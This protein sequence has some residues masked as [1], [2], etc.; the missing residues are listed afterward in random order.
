MTP[1]S[2]CICAKGAFLTSLTSQ[3]CGKAYMLLS[4][5]LIPEEKEDM[6]RALPT[7][8]AIGLFQV[9]EAL[10]SLETQADP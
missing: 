5:T 1:G 3:D 6:K 7:A 9:S 4:V 8:L 10:T 2:Y